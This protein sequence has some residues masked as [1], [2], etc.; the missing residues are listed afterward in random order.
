M[1]TS[2]NQF[3]FKPKHSTDISVFLFKQ[4]VSSYRNQNTPV[5]S[6]FLDATKAFDKINHQILFKKLVLRGVPIYFVRLLWYWYK[7]QSTQVSWGGQ[8]SSSFSVSNGVR[9]G[10][11]LSPFL[12]AV[13]IDDLSRLLNNVRAGCY[14]GNSCIN[15]ICLPM[16]FV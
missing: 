12:F 9:Q 11:V 13:Y 7:S 15:H 3:R 14:V 8:M 16:I 2:S 1:R 5:F 6:A 4:T 10:G